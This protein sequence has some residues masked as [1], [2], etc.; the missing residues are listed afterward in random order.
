MNKKGKFL[1]ETRNAKIARRLDA[2]MEC[3]PPG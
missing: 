3:Q 1:F 2:F